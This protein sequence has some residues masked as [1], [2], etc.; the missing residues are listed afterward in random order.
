MGEIQVNAIAAFLV[1]RCGVAFESA[2]DLAIEL[3]G[4]VRCQGL[5]E[6]RRWSELLA[7]NASYWSVELRCAA[8]ALLDSIDYGDPEQLHCSTVAY[9]AVQQAL[10]AHSP[11]PMTGWPKPPV[12]AVAP[13]LVEMYRHA[14]MRNFDLGEPE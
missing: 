12:N 1:S 5:D 4:A 11:I 9:L 2:G 14:M 13:L 3:I 7:D 8:Q 6:T 10:L